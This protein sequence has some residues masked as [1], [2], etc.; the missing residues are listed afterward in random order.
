MCSAP[1]VPKPCTA[2]GRIQ[3]PR[4]AISSSKM[5]PLATAQLVKRLAREVGFDLVGITT[6]K[7]TERGEYYREWL[8]A[9][10]AGEMAYLQRNVRLRLHPAELLAGARSM[11]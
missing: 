3:R 6:V 4:P 10:N 7:P 11:I 9:G 5:T 2:P 8:A 1:A